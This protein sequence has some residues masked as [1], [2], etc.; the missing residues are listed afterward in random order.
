MDEEEKGEWARAGISCVLAFP[1]LMELTH[2][3]EHL[4]LAQEDV[5][6]SLHMIKILFILYPCVH[7][8]VDWEWC[9][10]TPSYLIDFSL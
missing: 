10:P 1:F 6:E 4:N 2:E 9:E 7:E 3:T 8:V 5:H